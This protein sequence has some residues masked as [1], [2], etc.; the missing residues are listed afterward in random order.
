MHY[1]LT[2]GIMN[3]HVHSCLTGK[4]QIET[5][6]GSLNLKMNIKSKK[7]KKK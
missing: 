7:E 6:N 5:T 3:N 2:F 1:M 4:T